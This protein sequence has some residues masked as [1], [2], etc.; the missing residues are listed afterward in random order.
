MP[1]EL[2]TNALTTLARIKDRL[3]ITIST[4]D[5]LIE[6]LINGASA[7]IERTVGQT[8]KKAS[9]TDY[10]PVEG[11]GSRVFAKQV[12]IIGALTSIK[13]RAGMPGDPNYTALMA[14]EFEIENANMGIVKLY[15]TPARGTNAIELKYDA[16]YLVDFSA[17]ADPTKHTLPDDITDLCERLVSR[18]YRRLGSEGRDQE[19]GGGGDSTT[20]SKG[21]TDEDKQTMA[22]FTR[23]GF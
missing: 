19:T 2:K 11:D 22:Q 18:A 6:R 23:L 10:L 9:Y 13:Y 16:G 8:F 14:S 7:Y 4:K 20:W 1:T 3:E 17:P 21:L 5:N 15:T 12:P